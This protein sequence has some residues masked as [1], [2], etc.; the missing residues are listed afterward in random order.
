MQARAAELYEKYENLYDLLVSIIQVS[1]QRVI[2]E[3]PDDLFSDNVNFFVKS[4]MINICSYLEAYIQDLAFE[5]AKVVNERVRNAKIPHNFIYWKVAKEVKDKDLEFKEANYPADKK[6]ISESVSA[7][8]YKTIKL[9]RLLGV[10]LTSEASFNAN[11]E[12]VNSVVIKRNNIVHHNDSAMDVSFSD[13]I[14]NIEAFKKYMEAIKC[15]VVHAT[16]ST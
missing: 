2:S 8:P 7:N 6:E 4:Y 3:E 9:Y 1:E 5:Y 15:A 10:D 11:K 13:L 16:N 14:I 12:L